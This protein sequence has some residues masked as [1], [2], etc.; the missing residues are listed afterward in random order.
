ARDGEALLRA[1]EEREATVMQGTPQTW[2][3]LLQAGWQGKAG[4]RL[5]CG[6]EALPAELAQQL[7]GKGKELWNLYG[8]TETTIWSVVE[9][10]EE[11][12]PVRIGK[13]IG[14]TRVYVLDEQG[15][16]VPVGVVGELW[17][18]G[19][20]VGMGYW[21]AAGQTAERFVP[22]GYGREEG[23][24]R[25]GTGD[26]VRWVRD[27]GG[28]AGKLEYVGRRDGQVKVR[29]Y[30]IE[31]GEIEGE[32]ERQE[33][34]AQAV[35]VVEGEGEE[36]RLVGY[37]VSQGGRE[38]GEQELKRRLRKRLPGYLVPERL[39]WVEQMPLTLNGKVDRR[40]LS[41]L[42]SSIS[43]DTETDEQPQGQIEELLAS[44]WAAILQRDSIGREANF[45]ESGGHSLLATQLIARVRATFAVDMPLRSLFEAPALAAFAR[46]IERAS[47]VQLVRTELPLLARARPAR[48]PLSS[49]QQR[50]W[51]LEQ[52]EPG[53]VAY[54]LPAAVRL[55]GHLQVQALHKSLNLLIERHESLRTTFSSSDGVPFQCIHR[56]LP[57]SWCQQDL[58]G[59]PRTERE[60]LAQQLLQEEWQRPFNLEEGPL[61]RALLVRLDEQ[62]YLLSLT[63][64]HMIS[65]AWSN[66]VLIKEVARLYTALVGETEVNLPALPIQYADYAFWQQ[67]WLQSPELQKQL[68]YWTSQLSGVMPLELPTD[69]PRPAI[70]SDRGARYRRPLPAEL[71]G[72]LRQ[73]S[74]REGVT[75]FMLLAAA[76]QVLLARYS[77]QDDI[78][79][80]T[81]VA[82]RTQVEVENLI[83]FF[84]NTL[85]LR[86]DLSGRPS[87][88]QVLERVREAALGA[89]AHQDLPFEKLVEALQPERDLSRSPLFQTLI[90]LQNTPSEQLLLPDLQVEVLEVER[91]TARFDLSLLLEEVN[92]ELIACWEY[93]TD[94][95]DCVTIE[96]WSDHFQVLLE[97]ILAQPGQ[98]I[99]H[100]PLLSE[101]EHEQI[102]HSWNA[103]QET[104]G[105]LPYIHQLFESQ[106]RSTPD[107]FALLSG[108]QQLTY[109]ELAQRVDSLAYALHAKGIGPGARVGIC[110]ERSPELLVSL[111]GVLKA[112]GTYVPFD[113]DYPADRLSFMIADAGLSLL[114][115]QKS[116]A[117][118][119]SE[120][121]PSIEI[122]CLD[123]EQTA[124][125]EIDIKMLKTVVS[126][127]QEAYVIYTSGSTGRPKG[128]IISHAALSNFCLS[129]QQKPGFSVND[130]ILAVTSFSFDIAA[131]ELLIP[132]T[133]GACIQLVS[134]R[135]ASDGVAL[136]E[137]LTKSQATIMQAT[138]ATWRMLLLAGWQGKSG[139]RILCGGEALSLELAQQLQTRSSQLWN[140]YGPTETTIWST[141]AEIKNTEQR[142]S[143]GHPIA[144]TTIYVLDEYFYPVPIGVSGQLYIGGAGL[145]QGYLHLPALT[146]E[147][148][149]PDPFSQTADSRLYFT[150]DVARYLADGNIEYL[151]RQDHQV[152]LRGY[153]IE[154]E[155]IE[156]R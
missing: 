71:V 100:L 44:L 102:I 33:E 6:G 34:I 120:L 127:Q 108:T 128:T 82:N 96:R 76:F 139:L 20:S 154:L 46:Q 145:A 13:P 75:L 117:S 88:R 47:G 101:S 150:G 49:S 119:L 80:G 110:L 87:F 142:V 140:M 103:S 143:I 72:Q 114:L 18:A 131:L 126:S 10:I 115:S 41:G 104:Y 98:L 29:G 112:G 122:Y 134:R 24:R 133:V 53:S 153:R 3:L 43:P 60:Y 70:Q 14:N 8:P 84:V 35:V 116:L 42:A 146:A 52:L 61:M 15:E 2:R 12:Q 151:G 50:L 16:P 30:R 4:V 105:D 19:E 7:V 27:E 89:Y 66:N 107:A 64:H 125:P 26:L 69:R 65:D 62:E 40:T 51:F 91:A 77:G 37:V 74:Q 28:E 63:L 95:F 141:I 106:V 147:R 59:H 93:K 32:L 57:P 113:P 85:V 78:T 97:G 36:K 48:L 9:R 73:L 21:A 129:M 148:F 135:E 55:R 22:E 56:A 38:L 156:V 92:E 111:L 149:I 39:V 11:G 109:G 137:I 123:E 58:I 1:L 25:Y 67:D 124:S 79:V 136:R 138:P 121:A 86:T 68:D 54:H 118:W 152:K 31:V 45:F 83:G 17:I 130:V 5:L 132:L 81:L 94:L 99:S 23:S 144:N 155:E 90:V